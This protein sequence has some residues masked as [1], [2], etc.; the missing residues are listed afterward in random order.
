MF[1]AVNGALFVADCCWLL[2]NCSLWFVVC[3][4]N[5][6][7]V[8]CW[9]LCVAC[10][11]VIVVCCLRFAGYCSLCVVCCLLCGCVLVCLFV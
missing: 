7:S 5:V 4:P 1:V 6:W 10:C 9:L 3:L 2:V 8:V 11:L